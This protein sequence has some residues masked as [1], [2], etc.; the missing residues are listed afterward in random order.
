M[1]GMFYDSKFNG[2]ISNWNLKNVTD[3]NDFGILYDIDINDI[4][5]FN[6]YKDTISEFNRKSPNLGL[7]KHLFSLR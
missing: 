5:D 1:K 4:S 6:T 3:M 7:Y 2:D